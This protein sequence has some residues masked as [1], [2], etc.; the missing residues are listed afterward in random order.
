MPVSNP[1]WEEKKI[2][3]YEIE[4]L[5]ESL[6]GRVNAEVRA[7]LVVI[8][9]LVSEVAASDPGTRDIGGGVV[10]EPPGGTG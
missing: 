8:R 10:P 9:Q 2:Q 5:L 1:T 7:E 3:L 4:N 6:G